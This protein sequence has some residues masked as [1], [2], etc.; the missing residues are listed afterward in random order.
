MYARGMSTRDLPSHLEEMY[1]VEVSPALI[2]QVTDAVLEEVRAWQNRP[3]DP[4]YPI[5]YLDALFVKMRHEGRV[6]NRAV[7][8]GIGV[9]QEGTKQVW[10]P[11]PVR[12]KKIDPTTLQA[13]LAG[14]WILS[15]ITV[16]NETWPM[17]MLN[18]V[19]R[20]AP[21]AVLSRIM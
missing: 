15:K 7:F 4:I 1:G 12:S 3:L 6:E 21:K 18:R 5:V 17:S 16:R 11:R 13:H 9:S 8:V 20:V 10:S 19:Q 2:R 14:A